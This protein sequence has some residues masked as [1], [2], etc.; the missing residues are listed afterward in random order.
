MRMRISVLAVLAAL[1]LPALASAQSTPYRVDLIIFLNQATPNG[2]PDELSAPLNDFALPDNTLELDDPA[3]LGVAGIRLLPDAQFGLPE[4]WQRM[5]NA[6]A[7][8]PIERH[9]WIQRDLGRNSAPHLHL[10]NNRQLQVLLQPEAVDDATPERTQQITLEPAANSFVFGPDR[11]PADELVAE[12][13][14]SL[15]QLDGTARLYSRRYLHLALDLRWTQ[16]NDG[17][18]ARSGE[19]LPESA[20]RSFHLSETR[21]V[22]RNQLHY[23]DHPRFGV[24]ARVT[25]VE[26]NNDSNN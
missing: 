24:L 15:Y 16:M 10:R 7:F 12:E 18:A 2:A 9:S 23:F 13:P 1:L 25:R 19:L 21:R 8:L 4:P 3:G 14:I 5:R 17:S 22:R 26:P 20:L 11:E 6:R